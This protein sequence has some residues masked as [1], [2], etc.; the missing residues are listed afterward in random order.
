M[1][2]TGVQRLHPDASAL[3]CCQE[4]GARC[5]QALRAR[6]RE[7]VLVDEQSGLAEGDSCQPWGLYA[8]GHRHLGEGW[9][10]AWEGMRHREEEEKHQGFLEVGE[11]G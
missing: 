2:G 11:A 10:E 8:S 1:N 3:V 5:G 9:K 7:V 4:T 6:G